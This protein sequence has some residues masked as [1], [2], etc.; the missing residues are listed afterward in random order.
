MP[1][2]IDIENQAQAGEL[3][4]NFRWEDGFVRELHLVSPSYVTREPRSVV[5]WGAYPTARAL[6]TTQGAAPPAVE[7]LFVG[8]QDLEL[9]FRGDLDPAVS[10]EEGC[11]E[12]RFHKDS[13]SAVRCSSLRYA[14]PDPSCLG[15][16]LRYGR[17]H[18]FDRGGS[19][20][21]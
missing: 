13:P 1:S 7:L 3:L 6:I 19:P 2:W 5:A 8:I 18:V 10:L 17:E 16:A 15:Y 20:V 21:L 11:V 9:W 4:R 12:W 14:W